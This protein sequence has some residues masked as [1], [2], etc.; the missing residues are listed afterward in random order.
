MTKTVNA[1]APKAPK[2]NTAKNAAA[3]NVEKTTAV[4]EAAVLPNPVIETASTSAVAAVV[5]TLTGTPESLIANG[6][7]LNGTPMDLAGF[8][9]LRKHFYKKAIDTSGF[10]PKPQGQKGKA[11]EIVELYNTAGFEFSYAE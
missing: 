5:K 1:T 8:T 3:P 9:I 11:K 7:R 4:V 6:I 2:S 10:M